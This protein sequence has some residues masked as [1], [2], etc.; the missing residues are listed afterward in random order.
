[1]IALAIAAVVAPVVAAW[2]HELT[3]AAAA[4]LLGGDVLRVDLLSLFVD[5]RFEPHDPTRERVVLLA[6]A[7]V[8]LPLGAVALILWNGSVTAWTLVGVLAWTIFT[9]NGGAH[10]ELRLSPVTTGQ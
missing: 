8:G 6:P 7:L 9:L 2:A 1:M 4:W 10:G 5:Y 3:H